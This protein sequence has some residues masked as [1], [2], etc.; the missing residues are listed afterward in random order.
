MASQKKYTSIV[1]VNRDYLQLYNDGLTDIASM[2]LDP[3]VITDV[4]IVDSKT[5]TAQVSTFIDQAKIVP[6]DVMIIFSEA[7]CFS[8]DIKPVDEIKDK[9][10]IQDFSSS[11]PFESILIKTYPTASGLRIIAVNANLYRQINSVFES[12]GFLPAS[13]IPTFVLGEQNYAKTNLDKEMAK[14]VL[15]SLDNFKKQ[16]FL[17]ISAP[18]AQ[19][20]TT[21]KKESF[22]MTKKAAILLGVFGAGIIILIILIVSRLIT[23]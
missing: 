3:K 7:I 13:V 4:E 11:V 14:F 22:K 6:S 19:E 17:E 16:S 21:V 10:A 18:V 23:P 8:Q 12:K 20:K 5:F 1:F 2:A 15:D 9:K